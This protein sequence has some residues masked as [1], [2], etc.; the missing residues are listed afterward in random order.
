MRISTY[1]SSDIRP[2]AEESLLKNSEFLNLHR[3]IHFA[4]QGHCDERGSQEY[5]LGLGDRRATAAK[6]HGEP[7]NR[8]RPHT[9]DKLMAK[10]APSA[11]NT[12]RRAGNRT[13]GPT[14]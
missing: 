13:A 3:D 12:T 8:P 1:N 5:N 10:N 11:P 2:D 4:I 6:I 7:R 9:N 14:L